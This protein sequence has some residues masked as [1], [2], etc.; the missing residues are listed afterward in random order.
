MIIVKVCDL[1]LDSLCLEEFLIEEFNVIFWDLNFAFVL[2]VCRERRE[3]V[4]ME[5]VILFYEF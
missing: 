2:Y 1:E 4:E 3:K 5:M